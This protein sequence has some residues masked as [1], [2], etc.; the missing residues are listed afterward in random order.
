M[1]GYIALPNIHPT[2]ALGT[3]NENLE[4]FG[5][6]VVAVGD[7]N[8]DGVIDFAVGDPYDDVFGVDQ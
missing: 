8:N 4:Q 2:P 7:I 6:S 1:S 5:Q 3:E